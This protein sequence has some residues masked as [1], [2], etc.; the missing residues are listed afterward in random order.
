MSRLV[1]LLAVW[2]DEDG[3]GHHLRDLR[4]STSRPRWQDDVQLQ[5]KHIK[6]SALSNACMRGIHQ[7]RGRHLSP[8]VDCGAV[9]IRV[10]L[11]EEGNFRTVD[12][13][14]ALDWLSIARREGC[15]R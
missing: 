3:R 13:C 11:H 5:Y 2:A 1:I 7:Y 12:Q 10:L 14:K 6:Y 4:G 15:R 8:E 9:W